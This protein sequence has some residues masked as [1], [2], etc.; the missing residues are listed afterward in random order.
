M[1]DSW[2]CLKCLH[3]HSVTN[4]EAR[5]IKSEWIMSSLWDLVMN[6][7]IITGLNGFTPIIKKHAG[8]NKK[9]RCVLTWWGTARHSGK[10][11]KSQTEAEV[12]V[13]VGGALY[14]LWATDLT[15]NRVCEPA[16][17]NVKLIHLLC[18]KFCIFWKD[19]LN[20]ACPKCGPGASC[21]PRNNFKWPLVCLS[22]YT[23]RKQMF[24]V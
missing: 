12:S 21:G 14:I 2:M 7:L 20:Q 15:N 17:G 13:P 19:L 3:V 9:L 5:S 6:N 16:G 24:A 11:R 10:C 22:K 23:L 18:K 8:G 1:L 4:K